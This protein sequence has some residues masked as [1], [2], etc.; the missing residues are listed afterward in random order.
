MYINHII[1]LDNLVF[2]GYD[3]NDNK[4]PELRVFC[5]CFAIC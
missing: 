4:Y 3:K 1:L 2:T 5:A